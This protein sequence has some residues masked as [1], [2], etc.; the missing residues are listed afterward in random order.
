M[1][2]PAARAG[3]SLIADRME[4]SRM[5]LGAAYLLAC[6]TGVVL[7]SVVL[8]P[9]ADFARRLGAGILIA[10]MITFTVL[11]TGDGRSR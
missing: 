11:A 7:V 8:M 4:R 9:D 1:A 3:V 2:P 6:F 5:R 10:L